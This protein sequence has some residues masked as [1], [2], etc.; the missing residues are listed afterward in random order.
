[1][2]QLVFLA[3][4]SIQCMNAASIEGHD[5]TACKRTLYSQT[6]LGGLVAEVTIITLASGVAP[7]K[8]VDRHII[9]AEKIATMDL[10][11]KEVSTLIEELLYHS[12]LY[13]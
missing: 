2:G 11:L 12:S 7:R 3:F 10:N 1:M 9:K 6:G 13:L 5:W 8:Y 4:S